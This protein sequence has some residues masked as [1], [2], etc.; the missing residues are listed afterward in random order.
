[1]IF[2][3][4]ADHQPALGHSM[5]FPLWVSLISSPPPLTYRLLLCR[6]LPKCMVNR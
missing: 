5:D 4:S 6:L 2:R 3:V 1:M